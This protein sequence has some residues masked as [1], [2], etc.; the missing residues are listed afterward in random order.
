MKRIIFRS[1]QTRVTLAFVFA[2]LF[3][4][5]LGNILLYK[6][7]LNSQFNQTRESLKIIAQTAALG[8]DADVLVRVPLKREGINSQE[9]KIIAQ[10]L[11]K[12]KQVNPS[13]KY[14]YTITKTDK[15]G[16]WQFIVDTQ[17][18]AEKKNP[19]GPTSYPGDQYDVSRFPE[20]ESA[21]SSPAADKKLSVDE[22]GV[23]LS[24][25]APIYDNAAK[26]VAVL[27]VDMD[28]SSIYAM[29]RVVRERSILIFIL[30]VIISILLGFFISLRLTNSINKLVEGTRKL[31]SGD[32]RY[33]VDVKTN[34]EI[35]E[36]ANS[37][38]VMAA[39]LYE[40]RKRLN[41]YFYRVVQ[42][43]IRSLEAKDTYTKGH[44]ERVSEYTK[45]IALE[46]GFSKEKV[47]LLMKAAELHDIGKMGISEEILNKEDELSDIEWDLIHQ[48]PV[49]GE[50]ILKP[51]F[52]EKEMLSVIRSHHERSDGEG[53]PD[54][55][56]MDQISIFAQI[57]S[58]ADAF[59]AMTSSRAYR[60]SIS[61][62]EAIARLQ[63]ES[64]TQFNPNIVEALIKVLEE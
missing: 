47:E 15:P 27:G 59:D 22:W 17:P 11:N 43:M 32:L 44:S 25:Y 20:M 8:I 5:I 16:I 61:K 7:S 4:A 62:E 9:F 36:L 63:K 28:A 55:L 14:I 2:L 35:G 21:F 60:K 53:Y 34:D 19:K 10:R 49:V 56:K 30:G 26:A 24:G 42:S 1:F 3:L 52:L 51:V 33:K 6:Y 41:D 54:K 50:D 45:R 18:E 46:L 40:T 13:L 64:G 29:Q 58:V 23:T 31:S 12:I 38:N 37:F 39:S 57:V 48:H